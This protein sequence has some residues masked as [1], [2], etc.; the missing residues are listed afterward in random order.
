MRATLI[1][2]TLLV[3]GLIS[4]AAQAALVDRGGGLIY[5]TDLDVTWLKDAN[6]AKTSGYDADGL[7]TW[8]EATTWA[9]NLSYF[10][11]VRNVTYADWRLPTSDTTC[12][13]FNCSNSE[14]GHL[15]YNEL[16]GTGGQSILTSGDP[17]LA[18]F[19][20]FRNSLYWSGTEYAPD[21]AYAF[22]FDTNYGLQ[23]VGS[24]YGSTYAL[25]VR[26]GDVAALPEA[27]T[28]ALMLAGLGLVR[29]RAR[30]RG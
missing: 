17:D 19:T 20:N 14:M 22:V 9:A 26:P 29:W 27:Q 23:G 30:R 8:S 28:Y 15:F 13:A 21:P 2:S 1:T 10:D 4:G 12:G 5:D 7:M 11:A 24:K 25:A 3:A 16:G 18:K 6:Y